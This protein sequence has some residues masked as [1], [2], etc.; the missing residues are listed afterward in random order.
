MIKMCF[1][2]AMIMSCFPGIRCLKGN[3]FY[4]GILIRIRFFCSDKTKMLEPGRAYPVIM[5][6]MVRFQPFEP[7]HTHM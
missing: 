6:R 5:S 1:L 7:K 4:G 2:A 3:C